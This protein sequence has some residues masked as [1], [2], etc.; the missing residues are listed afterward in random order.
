[1]KGPRGVVW[2]GRAAVLVGRGDFDAGEAVIPN[3]TITLQLTTD[4][5]KT[6][7]TTTGPDGKY[8]FPYVPAGTYSDS[9][10]AV[11]DGKALFTPSPLTVTVAA[12]E[13]T[14]NNNFGYVSG[15]ITGTVFNDTNT[16]GPRTATSLARRA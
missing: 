4:A 15:T 12:G 11:A 10:P 9:A 2:A 8:V 6:M 13:D 5:S 7:T 3:V 1:M 14:P 16:T